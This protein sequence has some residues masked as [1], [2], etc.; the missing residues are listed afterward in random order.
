MLDGLIRQMPG[1]ELKENGDIY[2]NGKKV[3]YLTLNGK[4]FFKGQNKVMLENLPYFTVKELKVYD[5]STKESQLV[6]H[7]VSQKDYVMD[8]QLK[9]EYNRGYL[10]NVETGA[11]TDSRYLARFFG[12]YYDDHSRASVFAN[13]NNVNENRTPGSDGDWRPSDMPQGLMSTKQTGLHL[14]TEDK[15]KNWEEEFDATLNWSDA[16]N[17]SRTATER[18]ATD[19]NI[20]GGSE[21]WIRQKDFSFNANSW[22]QMKKPFTLWSSIYINYS[23]GDRS[24][25]SQDSTLRSTL[26]N[27]TLNDGLN[28]YRQLNM[29]GS[30]NYHHKFDWGD[31]FMLNFT[32]NYANQ[33]PAENFSLQ[34]T[35]YALTG[36]DELR[37]YYADA[38]GHNY[39]YQ[40]KTTYTLQL[41]NR[42][43]VQPYVSYA[44]TMSKSHNLNYRLD[45]L[46][47]AVNDRQ[48]ISWLPSTRDALA[49]TLDGNNSDTQLHITHGYQGGL[50]IHHSTDDEYM[51]LQLPIDNNDER[52]HYIGHGID[53]IARRN[54][55]NFSP[56][57]VWYRWGISK[58]G[59]QSLSYHS[60]ITRPELTTLIP[61][62]DTTNPLVTWVNNP[63]LKAHITHNLGI[64][65]VF[66]NDSTR[67]FVRLW[68]NASV[69]QNAWGTRTTYNQVTGAYTYQIS[70]ATGRGP[71]A[72][73]TSA[74]WTRRNCSPCS[75]TS[76]PTTS[77]ASTSA[78]SML[79]LCRNHP[80]QRVP[81]TTGRSTTSWGWS[82]RRTS[83]PSALA[84]R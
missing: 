50:E 68:S 38:H 36:S 28:K 69:T 31:A 59:L 22:F 60:N 79:R 61:K 21:S 40:A 6:G 25:G 32:V 3:D 30:L 23:N 19:G 49:T 45:W 4:D 64:A 27:R 8:V 78:Y 84:A 9:R 48:Q 15:D 73:A 53:T 62:D 44:Q 58:S 80:P 67:R 17:W 65:F 7:D 42:W 56:E 10:G 71:W 5:K 52:V 35:Y 66:N 47:D 63:E 83:S 51:S 37:H 72:P 46:Q 57:F 11:G 39:Q 74:P 81:S 82:T 70:T 26:I 14:E 33:K 13:L 41:L 34:R 29:T 54:Y 18:F 43:Y 75:S 24:T 2:I 55:T 77:T 12:L 76:M 1:A 16:D 20:T